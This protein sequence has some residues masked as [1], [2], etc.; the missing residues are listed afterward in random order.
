MPPRAG[1]FKSPA[2]TSSATVA[3]P[4]DFLSLVKLHVHRNAVSGHQEMPSKK[5]QDFH[6]EFRRSVRRG[7]AAWWC[8][9]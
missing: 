1:D 3:S 5:G 4:D 7:I 2:S 6:K 9:S 8:P